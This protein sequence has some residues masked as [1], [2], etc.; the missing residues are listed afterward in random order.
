MWNKGFRGWYFKHQKDGHT[1][2]FIPGAAQGGAFVQVITDDGARQF[3]VS[4]FSAKDC[5]CADR[6]VFSAQGVTIDLPDI[7]GSIA[8][9]PLKPLRSD[10][11]GPFRFLPMECRHGVISMRHEL[12]GALTIDGR[13]LSFDG[14]LGYIETD[15]GRS[16]PGAYTWLQSNEFDV[17][18]S[19][20]LSIARIPFSGLHFTGCLCAILHGGREYR[21]ATYLGVKILASEPDTIL[22]SQGRHLLHVDIADARQAHP[23]RAPVRGKMT[24][25]THE[26]NHAAARFRFW[27]D[28]E[29]LFDL[30]CQNASY[31]RFPYQA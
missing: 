29:L 17:P 23:L 10:I 2:A 28:G 16:F 5:I 31:E 12:H 27:E 9:G 14:G 7:S 25:I 11:M 6:C 1:V 21:L 26:C 3:D 4:S 13:T 15:S 8:Y 19:V 30:R 20:M 18:C 24:G 22:L